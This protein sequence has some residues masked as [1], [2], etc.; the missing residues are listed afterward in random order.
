M[1][2]SASQAP[3]R[4]LQLAVHAALQIQ[5]GEWRGERGGAQWEKRGRGSVQ[6]VRFLREREGETVVGRV[7]G[8]GDR[9]VVKKSWKSGKK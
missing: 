1:L 4:P 9:K 3:V 6:R 8:L 5:R 7:E 2:P